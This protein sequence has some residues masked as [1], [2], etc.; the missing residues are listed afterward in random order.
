MLDKILNSVTSLAMQMLQ[1]EELPYG[2]AIKRAIDEVCVRMDK[3][4]EELILLSLKNHECE[5]VK[6]KKV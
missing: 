4:R 6:T 5:S 1:E 2:Q 3:T